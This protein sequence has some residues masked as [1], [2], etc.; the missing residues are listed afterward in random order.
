MSMSCARHQK[1]S[2][3]LLLILLGLSTCVLAGP[4][5]FAQA[6]RPTPE[7]CSMP[8]GLKSASGHNMFTDQ[9]EEWLAQI[10]EKEIRSDFNVIED[11][12]GYLQKFGE[13][14]LAQLPPTNLHYQFVIID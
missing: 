6:G 3:F 11:P 9:Q 5:A 10:M 14:L 4:I 7:G 8:T 1:L 12:E 13:R 2:H